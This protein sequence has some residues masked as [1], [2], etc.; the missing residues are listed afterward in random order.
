ME[1]TTFIILY[2]LFFGKR[3][4]KEKF[5]REKIFIKL[6]FYYFIIYCLEGGREK[7]R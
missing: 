6:I 2:L 7:E 1:T 3:M 4:E 5:E